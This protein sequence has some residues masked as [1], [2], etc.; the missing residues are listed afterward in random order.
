MES[1]FE[2]ILGKK[3]EDYSNEVRQERWTYWKQIAF[4]K[5][6]WLR[7]VWANVEA[8]GGCV[9]LNKSWCNLQ[10]LPCTVNPI[11][12]FRTGFPGMACMGTGYES[13]KLLV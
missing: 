4:E 12:S 5:E 10:G 1:S 6:P 7:K 2:V 11:V 8:C 9:H 3:S 13:R